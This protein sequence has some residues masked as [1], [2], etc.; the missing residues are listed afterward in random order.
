MYHFEVLAIFE[1]RISGD[2]AC[3]VMDKLGFTDRFVVESSGFSRGI[4]LLWS[5]SLV[6]LKIVGSEEKRGGRSCFSKTRFGDWIG[7][8]K[9]VDLGFI[10]Q[11]FT[12]MT[13]RGVR[14][15]IWERLD[16]ALYS[17]DWRSTFAEGFVQHLPRVSSDHCPIMLSLRSNHIPRNSL[18]PFRFEAM[19]LKH[20]QFGDLV[21]QRWGVHNGNI[22]EKVNSLTGKLR[23]WNRDTFGCIFQKKRRILARINGIQNSLGVRFRLSL[24]N[25]EVKLREEYNHIIE[26]EEI[27]W[28]QKSRNT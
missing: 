7:N 6:K 19:W 3:K 25:L 27:C 13:R 24:A 26:Q 4:W 11:K 8:N 9:L 28:L 16:R 21:R 17:M 14:E 18:K 10:S 20:E 15:E 12:W 22:V 23:E 5:A 1:P 2:R